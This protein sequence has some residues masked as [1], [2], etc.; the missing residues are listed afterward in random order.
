MAAGS[1]ATMNFYISSSDGTDT[2]SYYFLDL[3][4]TPGE[5]LPGTLLRERCR[6]AQSIRDELCVLPAESQPGFRGVPC[7]TGTTRPQTVYLND[8]I[9]GGDTNDSGQGN[10]DL[11]A[12]GAGS[13]VLTSVKFYAQ[14]GTPIGQQFSISLITG[15]EFDQTPSDTNVTYQFSGGT[16]TI[17]TATVPRAEIGHTGHDRRDPL[18]GVRDTPPSTPEATTVL[19]TDDAKERDGGSGL[20]T[21]P[22][23]PPD[24]EDPGSGQR[25]RQARPRGAHSGGTEVARGRVGLLFVPARFA[26]DNLYNR[27]SDAIPSSV[28]GV[29]SFGIGPFPTPF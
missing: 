25:S 13:L 15:T 17:V 3:Q 29:F 1:T 18:L 16:V 24:R 26:R 23:G 7:P 21:A 19:I 5:S 27:R 6:P 12:S 8:T 2:L 28:S 14:P 9:T 11:P 20:A 10:R 4:I 22:C